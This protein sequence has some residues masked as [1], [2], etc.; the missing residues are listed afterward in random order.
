M[1]DRADQELRDA[2][3]AGD[4]QAFERLYDSYHERLRLVA[5][6][7][8]HRP[9]WV[10]DLLNEAWCR[11]YHG[12]RSYKPDQPALVWLAG[13][14]RNV[15]REF[16]RKS[17]Q[18]IG[19]TPDE[20]AGVR[21]D[22]VTPEQ[23]AHEAEVLAGLN[24]CVAALGPAEARIVRLRFFEGKTLRLVAQEVG[25]PESTL[26]DTRLPAILARLRRCLDRKKIDFSEFFSAQ[27]GGESQ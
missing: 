13:I 10:D 21:L 12:R 7:I 1:T 6:R 19:G 17:P 8:S 15:Y 5:W 25:V 22:E 11:A 16:C 27:D 14:V 26:R 23:A 20:S 4:E 9:D 24:A 18:T 2:V 3:G